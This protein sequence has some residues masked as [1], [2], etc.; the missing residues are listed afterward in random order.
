TLEY[1]TGEESE[2]QESHLRKAAE[3]LPKGMGLNP[4]GAQGL[5]ACTD[6]QFKKG[7]R[8]YEN[9]CPAESKVGTVEIESPPLAEPLTGDVYVGEQKS[10]DPQ[11]G[12]EFRILVEA[13]EEEEGIDARLVGNVKANPSTGR[14]TAV[15]NEQ[16]V[17]ELAGPLPEGLP[18]VPFT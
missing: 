14:L 9:E 1:F 3:T 17:S 6:S 16:E 5:K 8:T 4:S 7:V 2:Q 12:E 11:S 13:K 10:R 18:Q 15:F